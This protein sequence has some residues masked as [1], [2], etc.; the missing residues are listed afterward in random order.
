M[1]NLIIITGGTKGIG[2]AVAE[3]FAENGFDIVT[4]ARN[5]ND[6]KAMELTFQE[7]YPL[8]RLF[9]FKADLSK[10]EEVNVFLDFIKGINKPIDSLINNTGLFIQGQIH[11]EEDGILESLIQTNLLSAYNVTRGVIKSM[12]DRRKGHI[13]NIC[14]TASIVPYINGGSYCITKF[15]LY[16]MT[17]VLREEM[18]SFDIKVTAVLPGATYT[19]S[20]EGVD[21]PIERFMP[22]TDVADSIYGIFSLSQGSNVEEILIRPQLGDI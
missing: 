9:A 3:K 1:K 10:K 11:S 6:L 20:W 14:S 16:G 22:P 4:C 21:L 18:K 12:M 5:Q 8:I 19:S 17:K 2:R 13:F 15:A 7:K